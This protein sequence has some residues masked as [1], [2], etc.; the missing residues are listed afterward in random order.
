MSISLAPAGTPGADAL[1]AD[2]AWLPHRLLDGGRTVRFVHAPRAAHQAATFLD[3]DGLKGAEMRQLP[4]TAVRGFGEGP[5]PGFVFHSAFC[6]STLLARALDIPGVSM[7]FKE[8]AIL[9]DMAALQRSGHQ[10]AALLPPVL[11]LLGR[12]LAAGEHNVLKPS[13]VANAL[14][15]PLLAAAPGSRAIL[16]YAPLR[17]FLVSVATKGLWGRIW[18][19]RLFAMLRSTPAFE[20]GF[21]DADL[22]TQ[23]DLQIAALAWLQHQKQF[24]RLLPEYG[25]RLRTLDSRTLL[26]QREAT[27]VAVAA[28]LRLPIAP[29]AVVERLQPGVFTEHSKRLGERYDPE[30]RQR[31]QHVAEAAHAGEIDMVVTWATAIARQFDV[32]LELDRA[33]L[34]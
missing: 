29:E 33:L 1:L 5:E 27:L 26:S 32:P 17:E 16:L 23:S 18:M 8:P 14:I 13:N 25:D 21:T 31:E 22:F 4:V 6:C 30:R 7:G 24:A 20:P 12:P 19:R 3:D 34:P 10:V 2:P 15:A 9:N 11:A 28:H